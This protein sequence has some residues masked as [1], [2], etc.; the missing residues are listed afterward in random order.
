MDAAGWAGVGA[1]VVASVQALIYYQQR[2]AQLQAN[3]QSLFDRRY[4]IYKEISFHVSAYIDVNGRYLKHDLITV[5][6][7]AVKQSYFVFP[8]NAHRHFSLI[9]D[10]VDR[11]VKLT[12]PPQYDAHG[13]IIKWS[14]TPEMIKAMRQIKTAFNDLDSH[15]DSM[16]LTKL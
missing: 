4:S 7:D 8:E 15:L 12:P 1:V 14:D 3:K 16:H 6:N 2:N 9:R 11:H 5:L 13:D 10:C